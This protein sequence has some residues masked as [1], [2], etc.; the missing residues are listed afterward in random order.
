MPE[1]RYARLPTFNKR[2]FDR[3]LQNE[4]KK[5]KIINAALLIGGR[6]A[7]IEYPPEDYWFTTQTEQFRDVLTKNKE[8]LALSEYKISLLLTKVESTYTRSDVQ[9]ADLIVIIGHG[10][11]GS[12]A[13][14]YNGRPPWL[15]GHYSLS[16]SSS[17]GC[18]QFFNSADY[19]IAMKYEEGEL[20]KDH[21]FLWWDL[22]GSR[23]NNLPIIF[24]SGCNNANIAK[25]SNPLAEVFMQCGAGAYAGYGT[26]ISSWAN[27]RITCAY[28]DQLGYKQDL[29]SIFYNAVINANKKINEEFYTWLLPNVDYLIQY[30]YPKWLIDP[31]GPVPEYSNPLLIDNIEFKILN[32]NLTTTDGNTTINFTGILNRESVKSSDW[33]LEGNPMIPYLHL[34][35]DLP[36][37]KTLNPI[38]YITTTQSVLGQYNLT[39][40][41]GYYSFSGLYEHYPLNLTAYMEEPVQWNVFENVD[42]N[43]SAVIDIFPFQYYPNNGTVVFYNNFTI[44]TSERDRTASI[45]SVSTDKRLY[46]KGD[47]AE[48]TVNCTGSALINVT[49]DGVG[50]MTQQSTDTNVFTLDT[51]ELTAGSHDVNIKLY[52][53][54]SLSDEMLTSISVVDSLITMS[55]ETS[56]NSTAM[57]SSLNIS[58]FVTNLGGSP[59]VVSP[60]LVVDTE[61]VSRI[62]LGDLTL[63]AHESKFINTTI[64][65]EDMP[66]GMVLF[67]AEAELGTITVNSNYETVTIYEDIS[68]II[69][70]YEIE[71]DVI[72]ITVSSPYVD[73]VHYSLD[74]GINTSLY[75]PYDIDIS[76][77]MGGSTHNITVYADDVFGNE[78]SSS[79]QFVSRASAA[80]VYVPDNYT[81]IQAAI[82]NARNGS[83]INISSGTYPE[84]IV[85]DKP[86]ELIGG[87]KNCTIIDGDRSGKCIHV[88]A[89]NVEISGFTIKNGTYG[90]YLELSNGCILDNNCISDNGDGIYLNDS[91]S[92]IITHNIVTNN[93]FC[94]SGIHLSSSNNNS[95]YLNDFINNSN[96][97]NSTGSANTWN[98]PSK[99]NHTYNGSTY[100]DYLG[101]YWDN[102][103]GSDVNGNGIGDTPY[104]INSDNDD[105]PLMQPWE[106]YFEA[107]D[108]I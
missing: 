57:G 11:G 20:A 63:S 96:N 72:H 15:G 27:Q 8:D 16:C 95:I 38:T 91:D 1:I 68:D 78:N 49:V 47:V 17:K 44:S 90:V 23:F 107:H 69:I 74:D 103:T 98:S 36:S 31:D 25:R 50:S 82:N 13:L 85:I 28:A 48:I 35:Y 7:P 24:T 83:I 56:V 3:V 89:N 32:Y 29:G 86:L 55:L 100:T 101:N 19:E 99:I 5:D 18:L 42:G 79:F 52:D 41:P 71:P 58:I 76:H 34:V 39:V 46:V 60:D 6:H 45:D 37:G 106:K 64:A 62:S 94:L 102:Y 104:S 84:S 108:G 97:V 43:M 59:T 66:S 77:L 26:S 73:N 61:N 33:M 30:G 12:T 54:D 65:T 81:T 80:I 105:Y 2:L 21:F 93:G 75:E 9:D 40:V 70:E 67:Y 10:D 4:I 92:N 51:S 88:T 14:F 53:D 87:D 22:D